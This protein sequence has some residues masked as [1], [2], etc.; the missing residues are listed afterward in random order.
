[1]TH[2]DKRCLTCQA[3]SGASALCK[4]CQARAAQIWQYERT[5]VACP[6]AECG[7]SPLED[8]GLR[9]MFQAQA[10]IANADD[11]IILVFGEAGCHRCA[12]PGVIPTAELY[13]L[14][15]PR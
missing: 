15:P 8:E 10:A 2:T 9:A 11:L 6:N 3:N 4:S 7:W 5:L 1:M 12:K 14:R 13:R